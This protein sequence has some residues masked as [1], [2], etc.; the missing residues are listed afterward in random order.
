[1]HEAQRSQN[2]QRTPVRR[3]A[4]QIS[5]HTRRTQRSPMLESTCSSPESRR[6]RTLCVG[7]GF[8]LEPRFPLC[9]NPGPGYTKPRAN[10]WISIRSK[11]FERFGFLALSASSALNRGASGRKA[12][13]TVWLSAAIRVIRGKPSLNSAARSSHLRPSR[14][15]P[16]AHTAARARRPSGPCATIRAAARPATPATAGCPPAPTP[17]A[18]I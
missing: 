14:N 18:S 3:S 10:G 16:T 17:A 9:R 8:V 13:P 12:P 15:P 1:M 7:S 6:R 5:Y 2:G 11:P 4:R